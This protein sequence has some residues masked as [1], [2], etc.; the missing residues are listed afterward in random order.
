MDDKG[1]ANGNKAYFN[2]N[3]E[4]FI[5]YMGIRFYDP[6]KVIATDASIISGNYP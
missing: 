3:D 5:D 1:Q 2:D 4:G 6:Q